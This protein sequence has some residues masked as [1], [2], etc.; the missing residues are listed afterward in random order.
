ML[1][2]YPEAHPKILPALLFSSSI[3]QITSKIPIANRMKAN[4]KISRKMKGCTFFYRHER[5]EHTS[6][7]D[8]V[9]KV[10]AA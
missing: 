1:R 8:D 5:C 2:L 4:M 9:R 3:G 7:N 10:V 6:G